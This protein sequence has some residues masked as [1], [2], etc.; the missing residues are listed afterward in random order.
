MTGLGTGPSD[1][2]HDDS[3][4]RSPRIA[5]QVA[6]DVG[7]KGV[8]ADGRSALVSR[9]GGLIL[10]GLNCAEQDLLHVRNRSTL[11]TVQCR[12]AWCGS[13]L[14]DGE[15]KLGIELLEDRPD[16]WGIDF[17]TLRPPS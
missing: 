14:I 10:C 3:R 1:G 13:E 5:A 4:R 15:R 2:T 16:F 7:Y 12:V 17:A 8:N 6:I 9:Y 11:E